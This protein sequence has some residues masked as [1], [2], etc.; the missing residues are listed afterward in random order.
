MEENDADDM[1]E[2]EDP[3]TNWEYLFSKSEYFSLNSNNSLFFKN[4]A[5]SLIAIM[6]ALIPNS[7]VAP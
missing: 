2:N 5:N 7:G 1:N 6:P 3:N 4:L